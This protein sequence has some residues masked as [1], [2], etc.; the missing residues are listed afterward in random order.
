LGHEERYMLHEEGTAYP[1]DHTLEQSRPFRSPRLWL[2]RARRLQFRDCF[3]RTLRGAAL[4][5]DAVREH[6]SF[7]LL[8]EP[9]L[10]TACFRHVPRA[11]PKTDSTFTRSA[12]PARCSATGGSSSRPP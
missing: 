12:W 8:H 10:A 11:C 2:S 5:T 3:E 9:M 4:L 7:E 6:P 1:V